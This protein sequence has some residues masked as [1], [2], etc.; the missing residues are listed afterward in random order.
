MYDSARLE[1]I[2]NSNITLEYILSKVTEYDI[3]SKYLGQFKVGYI[4][5]SPFRK[6][7]NPSFGVFLSK[8]TGHLLFKDYGDNKYYLH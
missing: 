3:Y 2:K 5:N 1:N 6:D 4:Y 8:K 7:R